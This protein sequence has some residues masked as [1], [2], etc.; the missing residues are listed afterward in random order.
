MYPNSSLALTCVYGAV[1]VQLLQM[2][3]MVVL[4]KRLGFV[5][6]LQALPELGQAFVRLFASGIVICV[7]GLALLLLVNAR[8]VP[9]NPVGRSLLLFL[10][11]FSGYRL[12]SQVVMGRVW[13]KEASRVAHW[14]LLAVHGSTTV[15][16]TAAWWLMF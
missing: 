6:S 13:P 5:K 1:A 14:F 9:G 7:T 12:Q 4:G 3:F 16:Y 2:P 8:H 15:L 11:L 10:A